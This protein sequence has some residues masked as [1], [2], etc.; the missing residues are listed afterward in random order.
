MRLLYTAAHPPICLGTN[1]AHVNT[2][3][4]RDVA[5]SQRSYAHGAM[6]Q[7]HCAYARVPFSDCLVALPPVCGAVRTNVSH[8][9]AAAAYPYP[10]AGRRNAAVPWSLVERTPDATPTTVVTYGDQRL[11][12]RHPCFAS[13]C[14][15]CINVAVGEPA[16][17]Q[18]LEVIY[19][20]VA[21][22]RAAS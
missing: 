11:L 9:G 6:Q 10:K 12:Q 20:V 4:D 18:I 7:P 17:S 19:P 5:L 8:S 14:L 21:I 22:R 2:M 16:S 1:G 15:T 3:H 13:K